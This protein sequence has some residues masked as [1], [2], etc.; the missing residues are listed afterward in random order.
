MSTIT[1]YTTTKFVNIFSEKRVFYK[2]SLV[3]LPS[4]LVELAGG[5]AVDIHPR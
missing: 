4:P 2:L 3:E 5:D 1:R